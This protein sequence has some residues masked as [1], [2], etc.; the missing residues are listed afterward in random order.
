[1][2]I[3]KIRK[4]TIKEAACR[5]CGMIHNLE[6]HHKKRRIDGGS[7]KEKNLV[8]L[9]KA[10][11]DV[12]HARQTVNRSIKAE[13]ERIEVLKERLRIIEKYNTPELIK[14]RGYQPYFEIFNKTLPPSEKC[15]S[16]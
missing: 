4:Q 11:H 10:C 1:M 16:K 2:S 8:Y 12:E 7:D 3:Q 9:C 14:Q 5:R 6:L 15:A 13:Q